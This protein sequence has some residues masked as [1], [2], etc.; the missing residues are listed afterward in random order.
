MKV[1]NKYGKVEYHEL[2][3][4][5]IEVNSRFILDWRLRKHGYPVERSQR[6]SDHYM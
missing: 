3:G 5:E 1:K 2:E 6:P 4:N